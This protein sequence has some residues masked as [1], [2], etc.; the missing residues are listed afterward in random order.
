MTLRVGF[1]P[2]AGFF[3]YD[4]TGKEA[5]YGVEV[6]NEIAH[7][8]GFRFEYVYVPCWEELGAKLQSGEIDLQLPVTRPSTQSDK[9]TYT[10]QSIIDTY[11]TLMSLKVR[12]DLHYQDYETIRSLRIA[13]SRNLAK[14]LNLETYL[15]T[16]QIPLNN[17][18]FCE[19]YDEAH[20][21]LETGKADAL[22][23]NVMDFDG[24]RMKMLDRFH[25]D[26][27][28]ILGRA[29]SQ[30]V[31]EI[32]DAITQIKLSNPAF[33]TELYKEYFPERANIPLSLEETF[34][35]RN[36]DKI[37]FAFPDDWGYLSDNIDGDFVGILPRMAQL[38]A[39]DLHLPYTT[40]DAADFSPDLATEHPNIL[41]CTPI[42]ARAHNDPPD[43]NNR[44][45]DTIFQVNHCQIYEKGDLVDIKNSTIAVPDNS[46]YET[47]LLETNIH[48]KQV[49]YYP[50]I[51]ACLHAVL[52]G[53]VDSALS[54]T[55]VS[56]PYLA[57]YRY[58]RLTQ[59]NIHG[60]HDICLAVYSDAQRQAISAIN[61]VFNSI[62]EK[63]LEELTVQESTRIPA[64]NL[65]E[66][67]IYSNP[68]G[69]V[70]LLS[71]GV[72][73]L[74]LIFGLAFLSHV[75]N[76]KNKH[77][78]GST[79]AK[80][81]FFSQLSHDI[82]TP[83][84]GILGNIQI[85]RHSQT[86]EELQ[87][88]LSDMEH[89]G[90]FMLNLINDVLDINKLRDANF[91]LHKEPYS[92]E[93]FSRNVLSIILYRAKVKNITLEMENKSNFQ[94]YA[95]FDPMRLQQIFT[96]LLTNAIKFTPEGGR[97]FFSMQHEMLD[98]QRVQFTFQVKDNGVGMSEDF[99][100]NR[101]FGKFQQ[102]K[103]DD[104]LDNGTG[105]GLF[106]VKRL[107][108]IMEGHISCESVLGRGTCFTVTLTTDY[109][110]TLPKTPDSPPDFHALKGKRILLCEDQ[111]LNAKIVT[112]LLTQVG[113]L[114][115]WVE[116]GQ[117]AL[118]AV[119]D[120][121]EGY[122]QAVLM[123]IRMPVMD[124]LEA[125]CRIRQ[126]THPQAHTLPIFALSANAMEEDRTEA[127]SA[128]MQ[129]HLPKPIDTKELYQTLNDYLSDPSH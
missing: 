26:A 22:I 51:E 88:A 5:G 66:E 3:S 102:E 118:T 46:M 37:C 108:D 122:Y 19:S 25:T 96:N 124:G 59:K 13:V 72:I 117:K 44:L 4:E 100:Q 107:V 82:R 12:A 95:M 126:S 47:C 78:A 10:S 98:R 1:C 34:A 106:I 31:Y 49:Q 83:M 16:Y 89:A 23:S 11:H 80:D 55:Y 99:I 104:S 109:L 63:T 20:E 125:S 18:L 65:S 62:P 74:L 105:L 81:L 111:A 70:L 127:L 73:V 120:S 77:L 129:A 40:M 114:V 6:L 86:P 94:G 60:G 69:F 57:M 28:I 85:A 50:S 58:N 79:Q 8:T 53:K 116:D 27:N 93:S 123:D 115:D 54:N 84:N 36:M 9:Y 56:T 33:F 41:Y 35:L 110:E 61:K 52:A 119:T 24:A 97:V 45:T 71:A 48:P 91:I 64:Q 103:Q 87:E 128:G 43:P 38:L 39:A 14:T 75:L 32:S 15:N 17:I 67:L 112:R 92:F 29:G 113:M 101:L 42:F 90:K 7:D 21:L 76:R 2:L 30:Y 121:P 68:L